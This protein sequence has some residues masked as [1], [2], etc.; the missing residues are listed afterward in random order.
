M[1]Y[2]AWFANSTKGIRLNIAVRILAGLVQAIIDLY[3]VWLSRQ[4]IDTV[5][6]EGSGDDIFRAVLWLF[7]SVSVAVLLRVAYYYLTVKAGVVQSNSV[8]AR[9]Y[10][11]LFS[12]PL[13]TGKSLHSGD[14]ASRL[15]KDIELVSEV[16]TD[17]L[18]Q[19]LII[20]VE[21]LGAFLLLHY[22]DARLAWLLLV[23]TPLTVASGKFISY[24]L[25]T[26]THGIRDEESRIQMQVQE[27]IE[28]NAVL[29][30]L[31]SRGFMA[32]TLENMHNAL[33]LK[34][35]RRTRFMV[36]IRV[37]M[38]LTFSL[39]YMAAFVWGG[40]QLKNGSI[41]FGTMTS[42]LQLVGLVQSP[43]YTLLNFL[44]KVAQS[45]ASIDRLEQM[46]VSPDEEAPSSTP[47]DKPVGI[48]F[49]DV[50]FR[51]SDNGE[52]V[53]DG[54]SHSFAPGSKTAVS[55]RTGIGKTTL[56][57]LMLAFIK[58]SAGKITLCAGGSPTPL[59]PALR[60]NFVFVPQGNT[61]ISGTIRFN[62]LIAD[63][64][65]NDQRLKDVLHTACADFVFDMPLGIDTL[66]GER[67]GGLSEGQAQRIAIAR[68]LLRR[69]QVFLLDEISSALDEQTEKE[70][71]RRMFEAYPDKTMIFITH[72]PSLY[73]W[74]SAKINID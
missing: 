25:R 58:P 33:L 69:G 64:F 52:M 36:I 50:S 59:T 71:Y 20:G 60:S 34:T 4:F 44:P 57:R 8:R 67:G 51:Y 49:K 26:L 42:F 48:D 22:F 63:P 19:I 14:V 6:P 66:L 72:R 37:L 65:A 73:G 30:S 28:Q 32:K 53:I 46:E 7:A 17:I 13:Y 47:S 55:G 39:G 24:R 11:R 56:F 5:I 2:V 41:T 61:L 38:G 12:T 3:V 10:N 35:M 74:C 54:F 9:I 31:G 62:L 40:L 68:G 27:S 70:L 18:P 43:I 16:S 15:A 29:R 1:S 23:V 21:L 45:T